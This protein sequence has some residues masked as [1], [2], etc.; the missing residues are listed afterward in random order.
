MQV[1]SMI[2]TRTARIRMPMRWSSPLQAVLALVVI[3]GVAP[4]GLSLAA[5]PCRFSADLEVTIDA[6]GIER[7]NIDAAEGDLAVQ[8]HAD[9]SQIRVTGRA[10]AKSE[11][12]VQQIQLLSNTEGI[13][14]YIEAKIPSRRGRSSNATL[15]LKV[16]VPSHMALIVRDTTG[17]VLV[18]NVA[19]L[20]LQDGTGGIE[21]ESVSGGVSI[22][23]GTG[24]TVIRG[25]GGSLQLKDGTGEVEISDVQGSVSVDDGTGAMTVSEV[26]GSVDLKDGTGDIE[27]EG[28]AG[29][30]AVQDGSGDVSISRVEG[31]LAL[32][33][34]SGR[35]RL[36]EIQGSV[37]VSK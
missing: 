26:G 30:V 2:A 18:R 23:D 33:S 29:S 8:G 20:Q 24:A 35:V 3:L 22:T 27:V 25:V 31:S 5:P 37:A 34:G 32:R 1:L 9:L 15:D 10:C 12:A 7:V 6:L 14:A 4:G 19:A 11:A 17:E 21:V 13:D 36:A 16:A 28:I